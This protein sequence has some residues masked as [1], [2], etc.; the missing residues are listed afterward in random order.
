LR[1]GAN[2]CSDREGPLSITHLS[3][4]S[5]TPW[6]AASG[7]GPSLPLRDCQPEY[8][9]LGNVLYYRGSIPGLYGDNKP[10]QVVIAITIKMGNNAS[11]VAS[12]SLIKDFSNLKEIVMV[13]IAGGVPGEQGSED[14]VRLGD[15]VVSSGLLQYDFVKIED[16][17]ET[18]RGQLQP[19][20]RELLQIANDLEAGRRLGQHPWEA[21]ICDISSKTENGSRP[22]KDT[23]P[24]D[25]FRTAPDT[26]PRR[27]G[28][29]PVIHHGIIGSANI[30]LKSERVR[31]QLKKRHKVL[32][33]EMEGSGISDASWS[34]KTGYLLIRGICDYCDKSKND[35]WQ[36][37]AAAAAAG[38]MRALIERIPVQRLSVF[39]R[40]G[41]SIERASQLTAGK[42]Q[43]EL[44]PPVLL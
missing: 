15:I 13:G 27:R 29:Q 36:E 10:H 17:K 20:S 18:W 38:Y 7:H 35:V 37:Y 32:A 44:P 34:F 14:D 9:D 6:M 24:H 41:E 43:P 33:V 23:D 40:L 42:L 1:R 25:I 12:T 30:L 4:S 16:S 5:Q 8:N 3:R 11:A 21:H 26:D 2:E 39:D 31:D 22:P 28:D 19:P